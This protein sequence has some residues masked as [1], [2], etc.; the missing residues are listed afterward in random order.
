MRLPPPTVNRAAEGAGAGERLGARTGLGE[1]HGA[2]AILNATT[3]AGGGVAGADSQSGSARR[4]GVGHRAGTGKA[5]DGIALAVQVEGAVYRNATGRRNDVAVAQLQ[6]AR[7]DDGGSRIAVAAIAE[8]YRARTRWVDRQVIRGRAAGNDP[9]DGEHIG[10]GDVETATA[11]T[12]SDRTKRA[13]IDI[14]ASALKH[15]ASRKA[16]GVRR[17]AVADVVGGADAQFAGIDLRD[18]TVAVRCANG[19]QSSAVLGQATV[20]DDGTN[21]VKRISVGRVD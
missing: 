1:G 3:E 21:A 9:G 20:S 6:R 7:V 15:P 10:T 18:P 16:D 12:E 2:G 8:D 14:R 13:E 17:G 11:H 19:D 5:A 4:R